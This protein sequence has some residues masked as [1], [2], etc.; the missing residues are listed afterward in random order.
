MA[1]QKVIFKMSLKDLE[2]ITEKKAGSLGSSGTGSGAIDC[3]GTIVHCCFF[4]DTK[5]IRSKASDSGFALETSHGPIPIGI[6]K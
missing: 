5:V 1:E 4:P 3:D 2:F 6:E